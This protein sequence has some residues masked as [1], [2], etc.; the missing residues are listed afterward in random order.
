ML[1]T[2]VGEKTKTRFIFSNFFFLILSFMR[3]WGR[4]W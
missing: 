4:I 1:Q 3:S 2:E